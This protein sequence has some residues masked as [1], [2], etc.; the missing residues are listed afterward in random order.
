MSHLLCLVLHVLCRRCLGSKED[1]GARIQ[2][3]RFEPNQHDLIAQDLITQTERCS[4][5]DSR[6]FEEPIGQRGPVPA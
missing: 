6:S 1:G 3:I 2:F 5:N 4:I